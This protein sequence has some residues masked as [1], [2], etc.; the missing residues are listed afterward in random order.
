MITPLRRAPT[1]KVLLSTRVRALGA[2]GLLVVASCGGSGG[3]DP[4]ARTDPGPNKGP[5]PTLPGGVALAAVDP[6]SVLVG[7]GLAFGR[8]LPSEQAAAAV[9][10]EE[11]EVRAAVVRRVLS[12]RDGRVIGQA[13]VLQLDGEAVFDRSVLDAF[14]SGVVGA[15]GGAP[16]QGEG[17]GGRPVLRA[18]G[19]E[20]TAVG[21][22][23]GDLLVV[24]TGGVDRDV[25]TVVGRQLEALASGAIGSLDPMTPLLPAAIDAAFVVVPTLSF[26]AIPPPEDETPPE[27]PGL[28]GASAVEGRYGVVA[29]ER[30]ATVW[31]YVVDLAAFPTAEAHD[32]FVAELVSTSAGGAASSEVE[33]V[34]RLVVTADGA[35][36]MPSARAFRHRGLVLLVQGPDPAQLDATLADWI[37]AL[38]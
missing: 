19:G 6:A 37:I 11:P 24:V 25:R 14:I 16:A 8:P 7:E 17:L 26:E 15:L 34:D 36:G 2:L 18:R 38:G 33:V 3:G 13:L 22:R 28:V 23:E 4:A 29:G 21:F 10:A 20:L 1:H 35:E 30:R 27:A 32:R 12:Q 31:A 5:V 9:F